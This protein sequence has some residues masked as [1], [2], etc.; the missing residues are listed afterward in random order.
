MWTM[1]WTSG[2]RMSRRDSANMII[3]F[4]LLNGG[5]SGERW[6]EYSV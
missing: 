2:Q 1:M 6:R 4:V 5:E 3:S